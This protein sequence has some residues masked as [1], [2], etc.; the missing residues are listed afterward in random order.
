MQETL[1]HGIAEI[2]VE[3][4][5]FTPLCW[6]C[7]SKCDLDSYSITLY[8][9]TVG[10]SPTLA[11]LTATFRIGYGRVYR[12]SYFLENKGTSSMTWASHVESVGGAPFAMHFVQRNIAASA[13]PTYVTDYVSLPDNATMFRLSFTCTPLQMQVRETPHK[14]IARCSLHASGKLR[15]FSPLYM[16]PGAYLQLR[17]SALL[18]SQLAVR[19][20]LL[21]E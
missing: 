13:S 7:A 18:E 8:S 14:W 11:G 12:L 20:N 4:I 21:R 19:M 17:E 9:A 5:V 16:C 1:A 15:H 2:G 6:Y 10:P 3:V